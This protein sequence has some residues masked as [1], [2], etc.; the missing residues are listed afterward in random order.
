MTK[1]L[2]AYACAAVVFGALDAVWLRWAGD[3]F[4]RP[5]IGEIMADEFRAAPAVAFYFLY[6]A[7]MTYFAIKPGLETGQVTTALINGVLLGALC[8]ATYDLTSQAVLKVWATKISVIDIMWGA[9]ATG[10]AS[11]VATWATL[12]FT[13]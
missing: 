6:L 10:T 3:N 12:R 4:Y 13:S 8:Y 2:I 11:A 1:F 9:F 5:V 7:G